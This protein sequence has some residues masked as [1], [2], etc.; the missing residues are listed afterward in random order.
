MKI[1]IL[2]F[3]FVFISLISIISL[4]ISLIYNTALLLRDFSSEFLNLGIVIWSVIELYLYLK[5]V[6]YYFKKSSRVG[7]Y[8]K[9]ASVLTSVYIVINLLYK[10]IV[11]KINLNMGLAYNI[12]YC[13]GA[14]FMVFFLL[15]IANKSKYFFQNVEEINEIG[16]E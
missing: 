6:I 13:C 15:Y 7:F 8:F 14:L 5:S 1:K 16:N 9:I 12:G 11:L 4:I 2:K 3:L 10:Y